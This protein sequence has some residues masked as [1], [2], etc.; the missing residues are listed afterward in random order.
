VT[1]GTRAGEVIVATEVRSAGGG[2]E[3]TGAE[4]LAGALR[5][6]GYTVHCGALW[7]ASRLVRGVQRRRLAEQG[8]LGVDMESF[9]LARLGVPFAAVR[10][11]VDTPERGLVGPA[12]LTNGPRALRALRGL[13]PALLA[14][15]A[16]VSGEPDRAK[17]AC[18]RT[19]E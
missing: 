3:T 12:T 4:T 6:G 8:V 19:T 18:S 2:V 16:R 7:T 13:G 9:P 10:S 5:A 1:E 14:W 15:S 17:P 11:I